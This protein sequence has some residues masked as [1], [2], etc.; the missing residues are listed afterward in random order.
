M[1]PN[2]YVYNLLAVA[3]MMVI[4]WLLSLR[5]NNVTIVDSLWGTGFVLVAWMTLFQVDGVRE[6]QFLL[7]GITT[8]WGVRLTLYLTWRNHGKGEDP[9]YA[10]WRESSGEQ[11]RFTSLFKVFLL[12]ALFLWIIALA[13]QAGQ[14]GSRSVPFGLVDIVGASLWLCGFIFE[15]VGDWQLAKFKSNPANK[16]KVMRTGLWRYTRH[17]NYFGESLIW[18]GV[19]TI[20]AADISNWWTVISPVVITAVLLKMTGIPLTEKLSKQKRPGYA[21]YIATTS[22]FFPLPPKKTAQRLE[23]TYE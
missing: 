8:L 12:Q 11:F 18:W 19:F 10:A 4:G 6:R 17:P 14:A 21:D 16:G 9:R 7:T 15:S 5:K 1:I 3:A 22:P 2:F 20:A 23:K 13:L